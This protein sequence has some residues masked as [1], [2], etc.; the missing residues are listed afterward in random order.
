MVVFLA[1]ALVHPASMRRI[2][3]QEREFH[4]SLLKTAS[5]LTIALASISACKKDEAKAP[6]PAPETATTPDVEATTEPAT[7]VETAPAA[8][9]HLVLAE[10]TITV[11]VP[12]AEEKKTLRIGADGKIMAGDK[13]VATLASNGEMTIEGKVVSTLAKDGTLSFGA[14]AKTMTISEAGEITDEGKVMILWNEDG[15]LGG[16]AMKEMQGLKATLEGAPES[17]RV[18]SYAFLTGMMLMGEETMTTVE[19]KGP[20]A[21]APAAPPT[22]P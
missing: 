14:T 17:R 8:E 18:A 21:T 10:A 19:G 6:D 2:S 3:L 16:E 7:P 12:D 22:T 13:E 5:L 9:G 15:T 1:F 20:P 4:M 11:S